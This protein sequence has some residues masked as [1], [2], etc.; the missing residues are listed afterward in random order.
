MGGLYSLPPIPFFPSLFSDQVFT[1]TNHPNFFLQGPQL[2]PVSCQV[3][4]I[5]S[6]LLEHLPYLSSLNV[7]R[8]FPFPVS[9][10]YILPLAQAKALI[11]FFTRLFLSQHTFSMSEHL[12]A[13]PSKYILI[14][15]SF[16]KPSYHLSPKVLQ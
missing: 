1:P 7:S 10:N 8:A 11:A 13:L 3:I 6:F 2:L 4:Q 12:F 16:K 14:P 9:V 5:W 15:L